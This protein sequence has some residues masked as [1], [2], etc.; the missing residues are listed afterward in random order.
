MPGLIKTLYILR[1]GKAETGS[2]SQD[3]HERTLNDQGIKACAVMG[4]YLAS[5]PVAPQLILCSDAKRTQNTWKLVKEAS[6]L[7][8]PEEYTDRLYLASANEVL[9]QLS[10]LPE[11]ISAVLVVGHNPGLHQ[12]SINLAKKGDEALIDRLLLKF[13]TC[14]MSTVELGPVLWRDIFHADSTLKAFTTPVMQTGGTK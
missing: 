4:K 1:H 12:L 11:T 7:S 6:K 9:N 5:Q 13:P 10:S 8:V 3:D 2:A 14:A